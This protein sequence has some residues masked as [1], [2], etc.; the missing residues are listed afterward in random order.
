MPGDLE[1]LVELDLYNNQMVGDV[2]SS[3]QNLTSLEYLYLDNQHY[4][5]LRQY[6]CR[7]RLP[8]GL[9]KYNCAR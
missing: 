9:D 2:P 3:L 5:P 6:Y 8:T 1:F 7:E 4:K